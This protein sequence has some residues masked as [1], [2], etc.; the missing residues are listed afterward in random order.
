MRGENQ[1]FSKGFINEIL[2]F[3][4]SRVLRVATVRLCAIADAAIRLSLIG[5]AWPLDLRWASRWAHA[6][7]TLLSKSRQQAVER[8][9]SNHTSSC[10]FLLLAGRS[11]IPYSSSPKMTGV[12]A[13]CSSL[14]RSHSRTCGVG[15][16]LVGSLSRL[17]SAMNF[18]VCLSIRR[19]SVQTSLSPGRIRGD[20]PD[21]D[22]M[23]ETCG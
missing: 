22:W 7:A 17:A 19:G 23:A 13:R 16:S 18:K 8:I 11:I 3:L 21:L 12:T 2:A 5:M 15:S 10:F 20:R 9:F 14:S 1:F 6:E 4:K